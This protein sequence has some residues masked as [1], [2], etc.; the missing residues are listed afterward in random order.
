MSGSDARYLVRRK[1]YLKDMPR[2]AEI[3]KFLHPA[4]IG[5]VKDLKAQRP[6]LSWEA[7]VRI[8]VMTSH[9]PS[10]PRFRNRDPQDI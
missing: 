8:V 1:A 2:R 6:S 4:E 3:P 5:K 7:A 9:E 10:A